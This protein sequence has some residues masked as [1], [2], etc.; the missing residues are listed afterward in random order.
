VVDVGG[1]GLVVVT[2]VLVVPEVVVLDEL[3]IEMEEADW[4]LLVLLVGSPVEEYDG[5]LVLEVLDF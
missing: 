5:D 2:K 4:L 1:G 3:E